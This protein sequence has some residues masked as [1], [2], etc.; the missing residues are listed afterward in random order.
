MSH[1]EKLSALGALVIYHLACTRKGQADLGAEVRSDGTSVGNL[2]F[3]GTPGSDTS[4]KGGQSTAEKLIDYFDKLL[5]DPDPKK[6]KHFFVDPPR[7]IRSALRTVYGDKYAFTPAT[8]TLNEVFTAVQ[9]PDRY[10]QN[11]SDRYSG[12]WHVVRYSSHVEPDGPKAVEKG[13]GDWDSVVIFAALQILARNEENELPKFVV[14]YQPYEPNGLREF[15]KVLG[16]IMSVGGGD[17]MLLIGYD[18]GKPFPLDIIAEQLQA[19]R[20]DPP[21]QFFRGF[22][23]RRHEH[24]NIIVS[25]VAFLRAKTAKTIDELKPMIG[26]YQESD[27]RKQF[28][29]ILDVDLALNTA[30]NTIAFGGKAALRLK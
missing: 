13:D 26:L 29:E 5:S 6:K 2:L 27:F 18:T 11:I 16:S 1:D 21:A 25:R 7:H 28:A 19:A 3:K 30:R 17:N 9:D 14:Y 15:R 20:G 22:V 24:G 23:K 8:A 10:T 4:G 12:V